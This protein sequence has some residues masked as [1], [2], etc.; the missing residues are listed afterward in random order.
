MANQQFY[1]KNLS[2]LYYFTEAFYFT[3]VAKLNN[4]FSGGA[5][6]NVIPTILKN[7]QSR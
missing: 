5:I 6:E 7:L 4:P 3:L 1:M 2:H